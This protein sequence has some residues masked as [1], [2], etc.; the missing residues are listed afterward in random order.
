M[1]EAALAQ[2]R[3]HLAAR[4][5]EPEGPVAGRRALG[6]G[7]QVGA[8][9][10]VLGGEPAAGA[11]EP[12]HHLVG[13]DQH[14][15]PSADLGDRR[16]VVVRRHAGAQGRARHG[17]GHERRHRA[18][19]ELEHQP[20]E[21]LGVPSSAA[22]GVGVR[23]RA[24]V[25]VRRRGVPGT[26]QPRRV[27]RAAAPRGRRRPGHRGCCRG[28]RPGDRS[29][30]AGPRRGPGG[31]TGPS[32]AP[33]RPPRCRPTPGT[34]AGSSTGSSGASSSAYASSACEANSRPVRVGDPSGL[35][36]HG[37]RHLADAVA[38][39]DDD[40]TAG[41]RRGSA[42]RRCRTSSVP[43]PCEMTGASAPPC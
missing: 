31:T 34:G 39:A 7:E 24:A 42:A 8:Q 22:V 32:S 20:L 23:E 10:E 16:P 37:I 33:S 17:L 18:R 21:L 6:Q 40:G 36:G 28:R 29:R 9:P 30:R 5:G 11:P 38:D 13:H 43:V 2:R 41:E 4:H 27:R 1:G 25:L 14:P 12:G 15:V 3:G 26:A 35:L 19:A